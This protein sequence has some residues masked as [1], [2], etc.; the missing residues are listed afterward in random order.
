MIRHIT[1]LI[2]NQ[3]RKHIGLSFEMFFSFMVLFAV[4]SFCFFQFQWFFE[5]LGFSY[6]KVWMITLDSKNAPEEEA[7]LVKEQLK[8]QLNS[9]P[10]IM[11]HS[12]TH[13]NTPFSFSMNSW[14]LDRGNI[15]L[16]ADQFTIEDGYFET[17]DIQFIVGRGYGPEDDGAAIEPLVITKVTA[18]RLFDNEPAVGQIVNGMGGDH[19]FKIIGVTE[20]YR[21]RG[22]FGEV[23]P[24][25]FRRRSKGRWNNY[26]LVKTTDAADAQFEGRLL[27]DFSTIATGWS[28]DI[29]YLTDMR[30]TKIVTNLIPILVFGIIAAFLIFNVALGLFGVLWQNISRRKEEI[31]IRRAMGSTRKEITFQFVGEMLVL[32]SFSVLFGIFF[33]VQFPLLNIFE[34]ASS[35]Y[36]WAILLAIVSIYLLVFVCAFFP[37]SQAAKLHPAMALRAE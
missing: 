6:E 26:L 8:N 27:K 19:Q 35:V 18:E 25:F 3:K 10:E 17:L 22:D 1:T 24:G 15:S 20:N 36:L 16:D 23:R 37:S 9:Y 30:S 5:P 32:T 34:I 31:G 4:F 14:G 28:A 33:A 7:I 29:D 12:F 2:W 21:Y 11:D 13:S